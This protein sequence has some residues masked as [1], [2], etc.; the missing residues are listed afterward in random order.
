MRLGARVR[1]DF[2]YDVDVTKQVAED[3]ANGGEKTEFKSSQD[4]TSASKG[5]EVDMQE[6]EKLSQSAPFALRDVDLSIPRGPLF[7]LAH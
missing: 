2:Q 5:G 7:L 6:S 3:K 4:T 1:G